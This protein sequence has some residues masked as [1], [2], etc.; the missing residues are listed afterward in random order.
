MF[1][2]VKG[3]DILALADK[4]VPGCTPTHVRMNGPH[5]EIHYLPPKTP[6]PKSKAKVEAPKDE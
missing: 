1:M 5:L 3:E 6:K 4:E 2:K